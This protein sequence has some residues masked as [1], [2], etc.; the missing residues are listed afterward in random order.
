MTLILF[1]FC[2]CLNS[3]TVLDTVCT[4]VSFS[5]FDGVVQN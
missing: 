2:V 5:I 1:T 4:V 3:L